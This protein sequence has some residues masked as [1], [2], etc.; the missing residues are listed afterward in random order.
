[1]T[2]IQGA[3]RQSAEKPVKKGAKKGAKKTKE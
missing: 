2:I 1:M 3:K